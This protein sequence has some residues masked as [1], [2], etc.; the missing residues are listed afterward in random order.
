MCGASLSIFKVHVKQP[1]HAYH[2]ASACRIWSKLDHPRQS[3]DVMSIFQDWQSWHR[4]STSGF[5]FWWLWSDGKVDIYL[6]RKILE[7]YLNH[8]PKY[9]HF[10]FLKTNV[11]QDG[12]LL[13]VPIF[14]GCV[15]I[16]MSFC[17]CLPV[18][19]S[20]SFFKMAATA[21]RFYFRFRF[22]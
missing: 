22:L 5:G 3:Y 19:T 18:M 2:S 14:Y 10:Q 15:T 4:H 1:W 20:Y 21:L 9:Y 16:G 8:R 6:H 7:W 12:I 17:I 11:R 13:P